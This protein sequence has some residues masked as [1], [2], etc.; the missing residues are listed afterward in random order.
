MWVSW[1]RVEEK[2]EGRDGSGVI[3]TKSKQKML[4]C[5]VQSD[6]SEKGNEAG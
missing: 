3:F 4:K 1:E 5:K 2:R 6:L